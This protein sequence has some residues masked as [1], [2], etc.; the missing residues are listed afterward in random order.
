MTPPISLAEARA[1]ALRG[2]GV[3][4]YAIAVGPAA[5]HAL[6][7]GLSERGG[8]HEVPLSGDVIT[9]YQEIGEDIAEAADICLPP[10]T[11]TPPVTAVPSATDTPDT[12]RPADLFLPLLRDE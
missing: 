6:L 9:P 10:P 4:H 12:P 2:Q 5:Q 7:R 1:E 11:A 8:Y 3:K